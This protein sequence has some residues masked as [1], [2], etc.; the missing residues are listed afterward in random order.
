MSRATP[1]SAALSGSTARPRAQASSASSA[2]GGGAVEPAA[3]VVAELEVAGGAVDVEGL[4]D[5]A[6]AAG[7]LSLVLG[8]PI[9]V[10]LRR[11]R[12]AAHA[13]ALLGRQHQHALGSDATSLGVPSYA[14]ALNASVSSFSSS[15]VMK[16]G[17]FFKSATTSST[18]LLLSM[19]RP[20]ESSGSI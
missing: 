1:R 5:C 16:N 18:V 7:R 14:S 3:A 19:A 4:E 15:S 2:Q 17:D 9:L 8:F 6:L 11:R 10:L 12:L 20:G 13:L